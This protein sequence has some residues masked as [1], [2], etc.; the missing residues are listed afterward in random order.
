VKRYA[1]GISPGILSVDMGTN[2]LNCC[3]NKYQIFG[4]LK[5]NI[6]SKLKY[7]WLG[8]AVLSMILTAFLWFGYESENLQNTIYVLNALILILS[9]PCSLFAV[10][11]VALADYYLDINPFSIEGIYLSTIFLSV[12][13]LMQW[14]WIARFWSPPEAMFQNLN[15]LEAEAD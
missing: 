10:L 3:L 8:I 1:H 2:S 13:G 11:V 14:F 4:R 15:L 6:K 7:I 9:L 12:V 5:M